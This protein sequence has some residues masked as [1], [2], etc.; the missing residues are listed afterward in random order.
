MKEIWRDVVGYE[1]LYEVSSLGR[2]RS[3]ISY[4]VLLST[5][6]NA[7]DYVRLP[8]TR[9][10]FCST[11][12][13]HR[14]VYE[15]FNGAIPY[16]FQVHHKDGNKRNNR[17]SN[18]EAISIREHSKITAMQ[19]PL[20]HEKSNKART[21]TILQYSLNGDFLAEYSSAEEASKK[22]GVCKRN[23]QQV[24]SGELNQNKKIRMQAGG[25]KWRYKK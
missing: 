12:L 19:H 17:L 10:K 7:D 22:T 13:L 4:T 21:R 6:R 2:V 24:A 25:Y 18:L 11:K 8:L 3:L 23:I 14:I 5:K 16:G 20:M 1:D 15:A 9:N